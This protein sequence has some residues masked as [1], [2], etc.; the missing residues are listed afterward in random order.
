[1]EK[2]VG[3]I[4]DAIPYLF[5]CFVNLT[6]NRDFNAGIAKFIFI[7]ILKFVIRFMLYPVNCCH[8]LKITLS[9]YELPH[10]IAILW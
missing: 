8:C 1:M 3:L 4:V 2:S 10:E 7:P 9:Y 6:L 5:F